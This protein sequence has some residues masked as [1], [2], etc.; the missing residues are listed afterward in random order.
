MMF[1]IENK[2]L[3]RY[4]LYGYLYSFQQSECPQRTAPTLRVRGVSVLRGTLGVWPG[5]GLGPVHAAR[6]GHV[7]RGEVTEEDAHGLTD[8]Q[9]RFTKG[10]MHHLFKKHMIKCIIFHGNVEAF[11]T[12][13]A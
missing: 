1:G 10:H 4:I 6:P 3:N 11:T 8:Y 9:V 7:G 2:N 12:K 13:Q 5:P